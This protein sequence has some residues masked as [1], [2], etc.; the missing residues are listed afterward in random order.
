MPLFWSKDCRS[1][2][3]ATLPFAFASASESACVS[4][5]VSASQVAAKPLLQSIPRWL[6][7]TFLIAIFTPAHAEIIAIP[8]AHLGEGKTLRAQFFAPESKTE[9]PRAAVI[10]LHGCGGLGAN[11]KLNA[12]HTM[13][14]DW[15]N[16]RGFIVVFPESFTSRGVDEVCTQKFSARTIKRADRVNDVIATR[17]WLAAR[18]DVDASKLVLWGWSHGGGTT[19]ATITHRVGNAFPDDVKFARAISFYPGCSSYVPSARAQKISSPL[20]LLIGEADDW[21]PAAPCSQWVQ[22]LRDYKQDATIT[23]FPGAFHDF[24]NP[25]G[26]L[27][28]RTDVP[29]GVNPGKGVTTGPDPKAREAAMQQID[30]LFLRTGL[31]IQRDAAAN[32]TKTP[33]VDSETPKSLTPRTAVSAPK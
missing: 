19:L 7:A 28:V 27:R 29:N 10:L 23:L 17:Q 4:A 16:E 33:T 31:T 8:A 15:L 9:T 21:T 24:D 30:A 12:R 22:Q 13:W 18:K 20:T 11:G 32:S 6:A 26:K 1:G 14:K 25:G 5:C 3:A 2:P